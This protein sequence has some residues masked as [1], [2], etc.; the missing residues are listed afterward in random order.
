M[1]DKSKIFCLKFYSVFSLLFMFAGGKDSFFSLA[2]DKS[3]GREL[4]KEQR[5][6]FPSAVAV[7]LSKPA[8]LFPNFFF[9]SDRQHFS[10]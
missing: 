1:L 7:I 9:P 4:E 8:N 3:R 10:Y 2:E 6:F 5:V